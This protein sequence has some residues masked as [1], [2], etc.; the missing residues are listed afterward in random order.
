MAKI[1]QESL[2]GELVVIYVASFLPPLTHMG[3]HMFTRSIRALTDPL[4]LPLPLS[5]A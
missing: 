4:S 5:H 2:R 1:S 3:K